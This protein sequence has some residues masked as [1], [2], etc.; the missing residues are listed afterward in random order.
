MQ[1]GGYQ[2]IVKQGENGYTD[3]ASHRIYK[4][5][6]AEGVPNS[7]H[8]PLTVILSGKDSRR[9]DSAEDQKIENEDKLVAIA[10]PTM[11]RAGKPR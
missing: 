4:Y 10:A 6:E 9:G 3:K 11:P 5:L 2:E 8:V 7:L 1:E